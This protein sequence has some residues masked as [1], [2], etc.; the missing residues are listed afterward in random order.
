MKRFDS[1]R[2]KEE[3]FF[4]NRT[5]V[6][7]KRKT[8]WAGCKKETKIRRSWWPDLGRDTRSLN[9]A[10]STEKITKKT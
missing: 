7:F 4:V 1:Y 2:V 6:I 9:G 3:T 8:P 5:G 10:K